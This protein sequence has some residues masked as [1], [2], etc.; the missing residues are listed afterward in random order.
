MRLFHLS[1]DHITHPKSYLTGIWVKSVLVIRM[2]ICKWM[3]SRLQS[4]WKQ[5]RKKESANSPG[6]LKVL[7]HT[8]KKNLWLTG[9]ESWFLTDFSLFH[10][11][12]MFLFCNNIQILIFWKDGLLGSKNHIRHIKYG[13]QSWVWPQWRSYRKTSC[14]CHIAI[15]WNEYTCRGGNSIKKWCF[16][17]LGFIQ[18]SLFLK[19]IQKGN[20]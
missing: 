19:N 9:T 8:V 13:S 14:G 1:D 10:S 2:Y 12:F 5:K 15:K 20:Q 11:S 18:K 7:S 3:V 17:Q 4:F 16:W 6:S